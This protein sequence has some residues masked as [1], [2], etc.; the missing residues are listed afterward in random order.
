MLLIFSSLVCAQDSDRDV[1]IHKNVKLVISSSGPDIPAGIASQYMTFLPMLES[2][3]KDSVTS[4]SDE[5][6]LTIKVAPIVKE[7]GSTNKIKRAAAKISAFRKNAKQ[8]FFGNLILYSYVN[9]GPVSKEETQ[10]FLQ[11]QILGPNECVK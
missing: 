4:Q 2:A 3:L 1:E 7:I 11:K 10:Q 6:A 5:C 8:E 9:S